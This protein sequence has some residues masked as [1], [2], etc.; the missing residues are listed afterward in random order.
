MTP[1]TEAGRHSAIDRATKRARRFADTRCLEPLAVVANAPFQHLDRRF[2]VAFDSGVKQVAHLDLAGFGAGIVDDDVEFV[3]GPDRPQA[4]AAG[5][6]FQVGLDCIGWCPC[7][8]GGAVDALAANNAANAKRGFIDGNG[9]A[10]EPECAAFAVDG[11]VEIEACTERNGFERTR[12]IA[13]STFAEDDVYR[14]ARFDIAQRC[15]AGYERGHLLCLSAADTRSLQHAGEAVAA[16][17]AGG[18]FDART[19]RAS[20]QGHNGIGRCHPP[21]AVA[22]KGYRHD[23]LRAR[24]FEFGFGLDRGLGTVYRAKIGEQGKRRDAQ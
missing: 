3:G 4:G 22:A 12:G 9:L 11:K 17:E 10:L 7:S 15:R 14:R 19:L 18:Q 6:D 20:G 24:F 5:Q 8:A 2:A 13:R 23:H 21:A 16:P 1:G